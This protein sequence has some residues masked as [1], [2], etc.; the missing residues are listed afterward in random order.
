MAP[1]ELDA[2][3]RVTRVQLQ[4]L[5]PGCHCLID[6]PGEEV[7]GAGPGVDEQ[8]S[9]LELLGETGLGDSFLKALRGIEVLGI[10]DAGQ[11]VAGIK[12]HSAPI[13]SLGTRP[14]PLVERDPAESG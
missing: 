3:I 4:R 12:L 8:R 1:R 2:G 13:L 6:S 9:R 11:G 14:V 10:P 5:L 7:G